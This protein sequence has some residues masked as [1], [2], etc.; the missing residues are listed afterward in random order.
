METNVQ[1]E[2]SSRTFFLF[3]FQMYKGPLFWLA[4]IS[5]PKTSLTQKFFSSSRKPFS[6][7]EQIISTRNI[8]AHLKN[9][10]R[11]LCLLSVKCFRLELT[12]NCR[13]LAVSRPSLAQVCRFAACSN[14]KAPIQFSNNVFYLTEAKFEILAMLGN[15][16]RCVSGK[17][18]VIF[19]HVTRFDQSQT[20][21]N[22][23]WIVNGDSQFVAKTNRTWQ[24]IWT[25]Y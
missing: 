11:L 19:H 4:G 3:F 6:S 7:F 24:L 22:I 25:C 14:S 17:A 18:W 2:Q 23:T 12:H 21:Q 15:I 1:K 13:L 20:I 5:V 8:R 16:I 9:Q 10:T